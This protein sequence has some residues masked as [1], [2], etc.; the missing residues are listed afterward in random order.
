MLVSGALW[1]VLTVALTG[2]T[3]IGLALVAGMSWGYWN[4]RR[5]S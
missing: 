2:P 3:G 5:E 1:L 4:G